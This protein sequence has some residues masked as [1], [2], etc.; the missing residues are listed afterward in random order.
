MGRGGV[1]AR[2]GVAV[3]SG[4]AARGGS[5]RSGGVEERRH[6]SCQALRGGVTDR[7]Q[8]SSWPLRG[9]VVLLTVILRSRPLEGLPAAADQLEASPACTGDLLRSTG[10]P[11]R[12]PRPALGPLQ[13]PPI[14]ALGTASATDS[15]GAGETV[16][17]G[18]RSRLGG[19]SREPRWHS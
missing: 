6:P 15:A 5:A 18:V 13:T 2:G 14:D 11:S 17:T 3:R 10:P 8:P 12:R 4:V 1:A 19:T 7:W 9:G 16:R